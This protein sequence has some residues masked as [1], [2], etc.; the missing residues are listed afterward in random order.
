MLIG[1]VFFVCLLS[2]VIF[3]IWPNSGL[4][5]VS[6]GSFSSSKTP[7]TIQDTERL[8]LVQAGSAAPGS[9]GRVPVLLNSM[10]D[11]NALSFSLRF[12]PTALSDP[13]VELRSEFADAFLEIDNSQAN[14]GQ[15]GIRLILPD[16]AIFQAGVRPLLQVSFVVAQ[17]VGAG[18]Q[19][20]E[21]ADT[22]V[23]RKI[24]DADG[25]TL[26]GRYGDGVLLVVPGIE[27]DVAPQ[28]N[29]SEDGEVTEDDW[30]Q[31]GL[32]VSAKAMP[33]T[34]S[35]FQRVDCSPRADKGNGRLTA[36]DWVQAARFLNGLDEPVAAGG[37]TSPSDYDPSTAA[38][39][40]PG[41]GVRAVRVKDATFVRGIEN[42]LEIE[43]D[44][45]GEENA[46]GFT[47]SFDPKQ[48]EFRSMI[49][50][51]ELEEMPFELNS[52]QAAQGLIGFVLALPTGQRFPTGVHT[53]LT[54][55]FF[56]PEDGMTNRAT[57]SFDDSLVVSEIVAPS[58]DVLCASFASGLISFAPEISE[59]PTL[60]SLEPQV[61]FVGASSLIVLINGESFS[62]A[63]I[64]QANDAA[65]ETEY[66]SDNQLRMTLLPQD[67]AGVGTIAITVLNPG[68]GGGVSNSLSLFVVQKAP[69]DNLKPSLFGLSPAT[70]A[71]GSLPFTLKLTGNAF[72]KDSVV[73]IK[74]QDRKTRFVSETQLEASVLSSDV[75]IAGDVPVL[76][77]N[78]PPGGG[79]SSEVKLSVKKRNPLPRISSL[80]LDEN[81]NGSYT[82]TINGAN[83][84]KDAEVR[85]NGSRRTATF[86]SSSK[87]TVSFT[88]QEIAA[89]AGMFVVIVVN[90]PLG[91]GK[92]APFIFPITGIAI[93]AN[94]APSLSS[95]SPNLVVEGSSGILLKVN[96]SGFLANSVVQ[97]NGRALRT[98]FVSSSQL[99]ATVNASDLAKVASLEIRAANP[100]SG[101]EKSLPLTLEVKKR[102]PDPRITNVTLNVGTGGQSSQ[103]VISGSN[104]VQT[105]AARI[106]GSSR[107]TTFVNGTTL[108]MTLST[109]DL[110]VATTLNITVF[111]PSPG[112][113]VSN[114]FGFEV[115]DPIVSVSS[116]PPSISEIKPK[117]VAVNAPVFTLTVNGSNFRTSSV[118]QFNNRTRATD[119]VSSKQLKAIIFAADVRAPGSI[120]VQVL[121]Q[122][123]SGGPSNAMTLAVKLRSPVP[124]IASL[125][126]DS[127]NAG[128]KDFQLKVNGANFVN[129][130][131]VR[132]NGSARSTSFINSGELSA[133]ISS[134]DISTPGKIAN[135]SVMTDQPGGG[136][137]SQISL[138]VSAPVNPQ[139]S[140]SSISPNPVSE[141]GATFKLKVTGQRFMAGSVVR[142]DSV[143]R[144]TKFVSAT[145]LTADVPASDIAKAK[146]LTVQVFNQEPGGGLSNSVTLEV[147][148]RNPVPRITSLSTDVVNAGE[149][150]FTLT[151]NGS[152]FAR[153]ASARIKGVTNTSATTRSISFINN[154]QV[155]V[156]ILS[157]DIIRSGTVNISIFNPLPGGGNSNV[158]MLQ[159][160]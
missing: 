38:A 31:I 47:L 121:T 70:I 129:G 148:K 135:I 130:S 131:V 9:R 139:P 120:P 160:Q 75:A 59:P 69:G 40:L 80:S 26:S 95:L 29:G 14:K 103:L 53:I 98:N 62:Q 73:R 5:N 154:N 51:A 125:S 22:P 32:F 105:S 8:L 42:Q 78:P 60:T 25:N 77:F 4:S 45:S 146:S 35:E 93:P 107:S 150:G 159:V 55:S 3:S 156:Q 13:K 58:A 57:V 1:G 136:V 74:G 147:K 114:Q 50:G 18:P 106:N 122:D 144:S 101:G 72:S 138:V 151:I 23:A 48:M 140:V 90:P 10:G 85:I 11:E 30:Q 86:V 145:Q 97:L 115:T 54:I 52:N 123:A 39:C 2:G 137:S 88:L 158:F 64:A 89:A 33:E 133:T 7:N 27:A 104:F 61:V 34:G 102:N 71:E 119:F 91:G 116:S 99:T 152:N 46:V 149:A 108:R 124:Q 141:G 66:I 76:V 157:Q 110:A 112:G 56:V 63:S 128:G 67:V 28:P 94:R 24:R 21:M 113:G 37:A 153:D 49:V 19:P 15:F 79:L 43:L 143:A 36:A 44:S 87:F 20:V 111:N 17:A 12:D 6:A 96:G 117:L 68:E 118:V 41:E 92:S 134:S 155:T 109:Q 127:V 83:F 81:T 84:V 132:V 100:D 142:I 82:L 65:R 16:G 126:P